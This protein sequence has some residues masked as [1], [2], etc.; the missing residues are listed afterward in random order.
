[1]DRALARVNPSWRKGCTSGTRDGGRRQGLPGWDAVRQ[2]EPV[3]NPV[4]Q[5]QHT[6]KKVLTSRF[7]V[8]SSGFSIKSSACG[9]SRLSRAGNRKLETSRAF[10]PSPRPPAE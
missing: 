8:F 3:G 5:K 2:L 4:P 10:P 6:L 7:S 9:A 1:V